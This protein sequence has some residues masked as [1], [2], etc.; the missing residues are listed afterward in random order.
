MTFHK[1]GHILGADI[2]TSSCKA[3]LIDMQGRAIAAASEEYP[4]LYPAPGFVEQDPETW[5]RAFCAAAGQALANSR[6]NP[7]DIRAICVVGVTHN[8]VL[9][10]S[11]QNILRNAIHFWDR[12]SLEQVS[13]IKSKWGEEVQARTL[14]AVDPLW[15]WP[16]LLWIRDNE[17]DVWDAIA[18]LLFPK[19]YVRHRLVPSPLSDPVDPTGSLLYDPRSSEWISEFVEDLRFPKSALPDVRRPDAIVGGLTPQA[20]LDT[21]LAQGTPV[22]TGTTDTA[23]E[24]IGAGAVRSGQAVVKLASV[25]RIMFVMDAPLEYAA[26]L[27]YPHVREGL[28]YPGSVTKYGAGAYSWARKALWSDVKEKGIFQQM[29]AAAA[30]V[31][32]GSGGIFFHPHLSGEYAPQWDTKLRASFVGLSVHHTRAHLTRSVLEGVAFQIRS[33]FSQVLELGG[34]CREVRLIGGGAKSKLWAQIMADVLGLEL[35][36]P[37]QKSAAY[38]ACLLAG[39]ATEFFQSDLE[40]VVKGEYFYPCDDQKEQ[41]ERFYASFRALDTTLAGISHQIENL[42]A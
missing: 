15:T 26:I 25:G 14:N 30:E 36:V 16:Q 34:D 1:S 11:D 42:F 35:L 2:G 37:E 5:Y 32:A 24:L 27:N 8:P 17:P 28:W 41:Y 19:D 22:L 10:D 38:G 23:A 20:A 9:L 40:T 29:D 3:V 31:P 33:A 39:L 7:T 13:Q 6:I 4:C 12:R 21:G 18:Y